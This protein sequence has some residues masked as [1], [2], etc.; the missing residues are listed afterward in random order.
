M[1][2]QV[3]ISVLLL[4]S[5]ANRGLAASSA[6]M[7]DVIDVTALSPCPICQRG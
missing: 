7:F 4:S 1:H 6:D 2:T 3:T 5:P